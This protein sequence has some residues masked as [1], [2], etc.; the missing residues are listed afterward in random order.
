MKTVAIMPLKLNNERL[1]GK[2]TKLLGSKPL[3]LY[4]LETLLI[5]EGLDEIYVY[6][7]NEEIQNYLPE[8]ITFLKRP[9]YLDQPTSNFHQIFDE[10]S[11]AVDADIYVYSH[12]T[13]PFVSVS[14]MKRCLDAV[15]S[16]RYDSAFTATRI[17][18]YLWRN[19]EPMNFD[20]ENLP[21]SQDL[22]PIYRESSGVYVFTKEVFQKYHRR[23]G[24]NPYIYEVTGKE[25]VD[26][27]DPEDFKLA[28][29]FCAASS[30]QNVG[31]V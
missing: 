28:E 14:S 12:A 21:R 29:L 18:D 5:T 15:K 23:I 16:G 7:S 25:A 6:C 9:E 13:A 2:N 27:N 31:L 24:A 4:E 17:Q 19:G 30:I 1:P 10:F 11:K 20:A 22:E 26:I 3:L 8:G